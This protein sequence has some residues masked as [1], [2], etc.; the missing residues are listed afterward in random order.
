MARAARHGGC[1]GKRGGMNL[2]TNTTANEFAAG[3]ILQGTYRIAA[4]LAEGGCGEI[5]LADHTR[6][7]GRV[8]IKVL[9]RGLQRNPE[10]L[11]RFRQEAEITATLRHPHIVQVLDFNV[12]DQGYPYLVM[13]LLEGESLARRIG[14]GQPLPPLA[15]VNIVEQ[16]AQALQAAHARGIVHRDL[17]PDNIILLS[18]DGMQDF[19]KVLDFG[20]SQAS[21][22]PRLT[23]DAEVAGTPQYM[24]P[25]QAQ[26][27]RDAIEPRTDQ[28]SLA[29]IAYTL[30]T[31]EEPF[32]AED[33]IAVL[34]QVVHA[35][36]VPPAALVPRLGAG[37]NE[38]I[39]R[40]LAKATAD[41]FP[42]VLAFATALRQAV[43][44]VLTPVPMVVS[45]DEP[46]PVRTPAPAVVFERE[47]APEVVAAYDP[48][49]S[50][51]PDTKTI[52]F[53]GARRALEPVGRPTRRLIRRMRWGIIYR[54]P[55]RVA[56]LAIAA[57]VAFG[58]FSPTAR[59]T[60]ETMWRH[61]QAEALR[62]TGP[63]A[64]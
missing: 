60:A 20:I 34:Y 59:G 1:I 17:K 32:V 51:E 19:V 37:V 63:H 6:L 61:A 54:T 8:A 18:S 29:A 5:Y 23:G 56:L 22:R 49:E 57:A 38:V 52:P 28:F 35:D 50:F 64:H 2:E 40:G 55:R 7:P 41:R 11:S 31:G 48:E 21:W 46:P 4:S 14:S 44:G 12:T 24:A 45:S 15:A 53:S 36:P 47:S 25:E 9:H 33:P 26:G 16:I 42:S 3:T 43:E 30:L 62:L 10:V 27:L 13:E 58:W 39:L